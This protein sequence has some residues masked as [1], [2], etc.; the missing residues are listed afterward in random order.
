MTTDGSTQNRT[1][2]QQ[3]EI[4]SIS[5]QTT[6]GYD[7]NGNTTTDQTGHT[8]IYDAWNRLV[9][10]KNGQTVLESY[11]Y[12]RLNRRVTENPGTV[13]DLYY[14]Y[15][16]QLL[17]EDVAGSMQDQYV[18]SPVYVDAL[19]E[20]DTPTQRMYA[21]QNANFDVTALVDTTGQCPR[22]LRLRP[23]RLGHRPGLQLDHSRQQQL[24]LG[25]FPS[26]RAFRFCRGPLFFPQPRLLPNSRPVDGKRPDQL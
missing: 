10:V 15:A 13:R 19:I 21:E 16:W 3:N 12:D 6:P 23:L 25:L 2:N 8:L 26:R 22:A 14:D 9:Q 20:R 17:E 5:G 11:A 18:W 4:T 7:A 24:R 1:A